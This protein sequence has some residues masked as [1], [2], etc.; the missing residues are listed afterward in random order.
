MRER[1]EDLTTLNKLDPKDPATYNNRG[2]TISVLNKFPEAIADY[3]KA[4]EL[5]PAYVDAYKNRGFA[6]F[7]LN[8]LIEAIADYTKA[9]ELDPTCVQQTYNNRGLSYFS[10]DNLPEAIE[11]FT[12]VINLNSTYVY[13]Y[14]NRG[15]AYKDLNKLTEAIADY[16][17]A[18]DLDPSYVYAYY[19]RGN[20]YK[21]LNKLTE[22]IADY[23]KA[24][25][26]DPAFVYAYYNRG[27]AYN[28]LNNLTEAIIDYS[29]AIYLDPAFVY[30]YYNRG[31]AYKELNKLTEAIADYTKAIELDPAYVYAYNNRGL[32]YFSL[33][34]LTEAIAD[35][36]K[37]IELDHTHMNAYYNLGVTL[38]AAEKYGEAEENFACALLL[39]DYH[40]GSI[41][42][43][44]QSFYSCLERDLL[45]YLSKTKPIV[46]L[47]KELNLEMVLIPAGKF[48]M[49]SPASEKDRRDDEKQ[50]EVT[51]TKPFYIGK[52]E[53][54][55]KQWEIAMGNN[56]S[57]TKGVKLPVTDVSWNDCQEFIKKLNAKTKGGYRLPTEAE[58][59]YACRAGTTTAYAFGE[60]LTR[61][62]ANILDLDDLRE[63]PEIK[64]VGS[65]KPNSFGLYDMHGNVW[66]WCEDN[67]ADYIEG[68]VTD[69]KGPATGERRVLRG[70][71][72]CN[73]E[74]FARS[75]VRS[76]DTPPSRY[77]YVGLRLART[78]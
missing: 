78:P 57:D 11:D 26:L 32:A 64:P 1:I 54:T 62:D 35:Y 46:D 60:S 17:K 42:E 63:P 10:L 5:D 45:F 15:N 40:D 55:Q 4:I 50:H 69:P 77:T 70:G 16:T 21:D 56:P 6:Y 36:T 74:A 39:K 24:I 7:S 9:I 41:L 47:G 25:E 38:K 13:A 71:A 22:A 37:A 8:K 48:M 75:S 59:E 67:G 68:S 33:S 20:V 73:P 43:L 66:E 34:K 61:S 28:K 65:Y 31:I 30:A 29:K 19:D 14:Y 51:L 49:G 52:Y 58:W 72:F 53:V 3:T 27:V 23:T 44:P 18:I 2:M 12:K 76:F